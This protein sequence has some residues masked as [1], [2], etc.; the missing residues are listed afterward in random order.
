M[1]SGNNSHSK[2]LVSGREI[3]PAILLILFCST[4]SL[5]QHDSS[6]HHMQMEPPKDAV[7]DTMHNE[8]DMSEHSMEH[9]GAMSSSFSPNLP[10]SR[11][12]SGTS[13]QPDDSPMMMYMAMKGHTSYMFHGFIFLRYHHEDITQQ[14]QR[15]GDGIDAPNM[16][17]CMVHHQLSKKNLISFQAMISLD[18]L[19]IG[20]AGYPLLF[21][22]GESYQGF[23]LVD[24]Q[25]PHDLFSA[26]ALNYTHSF[27]KDVDVNAFFGYPG[28]PALGPVVFMHRISA[29]NNPN[30]PLGHHWQDATH[31]TLGTGTIGLRYKIAKLEGS[32]F[33]G[34]EPDE[35]RYNFDKARFDSYSARLSINPTPHLAFQVSSG[36]IK[37]PEALFPEEDITRTTA[38]LTHTKQTRKQRFISSTFVWGMNQNEKEIT[39]SFLGE[40]NINFRLFAFYFRY[41][42]VQKD[43]HELNLEQYEAH[44]L[45]NLQAF[46]AGVNKKLFSF[47]KTNVSAG[48][49]GTLNFPDPLLKPLYGTLPVSGAVYLK[50]SPSTAG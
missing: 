18:P 22:T 15:A 46:T 4:G 5:A 6:H 44:K 26:L 48:V 42:Y 8:M 32:L 30:A 24:K 19:T 9:N 43:A 29:M 16:F 49:Q 47:S 50:I 34:R 17:M 11:D 23:P 2:F 10:M 1:K 3:L 27:S 41:E 12:G 7:T 25:H 38:S 39:H 14:N 36:F 40:T 35:E 37:S 13:W 20:K 31:I 21:Q 28:E 45:F 33:T